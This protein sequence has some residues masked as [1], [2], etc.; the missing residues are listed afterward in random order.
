M[1]FSRLKHIE[2]S[3]IFKLKLKFFLQLKF[4]EIEAVMN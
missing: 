3:E 1:E 4:L 2:E